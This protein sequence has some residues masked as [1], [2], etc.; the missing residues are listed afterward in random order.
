MKDKSKTPEL[1]DPKRILMIKGYSAGIG[2]LLR[3]SA[4]W[5]ALKNRF[6]STDLHFLFFTKDPGYVSEALISRHHLLKEFYVVDK[7]TKG[8][9]DWGPFLNKIAMVV[10]EVDPDLVIDFDPHGLR[11]SIVSLWMRVKYHVT[12]VG[13]NQFPSRRFFYSLHSASTKKFAGDRRLEHPLEITYRD[14]VA[15]SALGIERNCIPI[16]LEETP[17]GSAFRKKFKEKYGIQENEAILGVNI[18]CGTPDALHRRP[19]LSL[20]SRL[21]GYLQRKYNFTVVLTGAKFEKDK[22]M[23][24][25]DMLGKSANYPVYDLAGET[26][27]LELAGLIRG[28]NMF[29][30]TDSGPYH[31]AVA[32]RVPTLAIFNKDNRIAAHSHPWVTCSLLTD[33][34]HI[35]RLI[36]EAERL[37]S[38]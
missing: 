2:D 21:V 31:M 26:N 23:E 37:L 20:L 14:F 12:T 33:E 34:E 17:E 7:R 9:R 30:S 1:R 4:A 11:T 35:D 10:D 19:N 32:L 8:L 15:L 24:F 29:I 22:N 3:S 18:G 16:E 6:P 5:R 13:V 28:C 36:K 27:L 25:I 38:C